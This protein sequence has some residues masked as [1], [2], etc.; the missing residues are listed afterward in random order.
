MNALALVEQP[1]I[2]NF[3]PFI[4]RLAINLAD[5]GIPVQAIAR[6]TQMASGQV[7]EILRTAI[8]VGALLE[9]PKPDWPVGSRRSQR[10]ALV[11][12]ALDNDEAL[13]FACARCFRLTR[14]E[15]A[16]FA[17]LLKR[18]EVTKAQLHIVIEQSRPSENRDA[19]DPKMVDVMI[20][21]I[22]KKIA[23]YGLQVITVRGLGYRVAHDHR[24]HAVALLTNYVAENRNG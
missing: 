10:S 13:Q 21:H 24:E 9:M 22:R 2:E 3:Q 7:Y 4:E 6:A 1:T 18:S 19:T 17:V 8:C 12:T 16:I 15:T 14:L 23:P 20:H 11:N 5:E